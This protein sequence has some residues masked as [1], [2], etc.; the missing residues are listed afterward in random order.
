MMMKVFSG[1]YS[2]DG[3][4][5]GNRPPIAWFPGS[6]HVHIYETEMGGCNVTPLKPYLCIYQETG[7][8]HSI[9]AEPER[10]VQHICE[11]FSLAIERVLWVEQPRM[12]FVDIQVVVLSKSSMLGTQAFYRVSKR[13]PTDAEQHMIED[14]IHQLNPSVSFVQDGQV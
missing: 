14:V 3:K 8:G 12:P 13:R 5:H 10:F 7:E 11:D 9:S 6:Y 1:I 2:W 4:R